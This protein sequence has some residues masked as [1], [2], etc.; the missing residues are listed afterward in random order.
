MMYNFTKYSSIYNIKYYVLYKHFVIYYI[1]S[2]LYNL[3]LQV[4]FNYI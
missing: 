2:K 4:I 1:K 3:K